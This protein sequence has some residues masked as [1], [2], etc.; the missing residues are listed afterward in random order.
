MIYFKKVILDERE[1]GTLETALRAYSL[2]RTSTLDFQSSIFDTGEE[3]FFLGNIGKNELTFTRIRTRFDGWLPKIIFSLP[4]S[5]AKLYCRF[6]LGMLSTAIF[7]LLCIGAITGILHA[8]FGKANIWGV[9]Q[10]GLILCSYLL[11]GV[12]ELNIT[13]TKIKRAMSAYLL[14]L[15]KA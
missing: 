14:S 1:K 13:Q 11:L 6:R 9:A 7:C 3:K 2:K 5:P 15:K 12:L 8:I 4:N 10:I